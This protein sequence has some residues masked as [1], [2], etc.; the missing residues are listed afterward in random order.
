MSLDL[1]PF[2]VY[3]VLSDNGSEFAGAF[4]RPP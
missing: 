2:A 3:T 1:C 4:E